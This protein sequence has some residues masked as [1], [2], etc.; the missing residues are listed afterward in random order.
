MEIRRE[1]RD[2]D[3]FGHLYQTATYKLI[4][5]RAHKLPCEWATRFVHCTAWP[6]LHGATIYNVRNCFHDENFQNESSLLPSLS[7]VKAVYLSVSL[8]HTCARAL[9]T[10]FATFIVS[11]NHFSTAR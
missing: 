10:L 11:S 9:I 6:N 8:S 2:R 1:K 7:N 3:R 5:C 4:G